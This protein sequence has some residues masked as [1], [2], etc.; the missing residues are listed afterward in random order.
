MTRAHSLRLAVLACLTLVAAALV[1]ALQ[2]ARAAALHEAEADAHTRQLLSLLDANPATDHLH[3]ALAAD[4]VELRFVA[5]A[6]GVY[7]R[8]SVARHVIEIDQQWATADDLTL[9]AVVAHEATHA[10]DAVNG[11]L[12]SGEA[13]A[14]IDS[15]VRA[16]RTA[17]RFWLST[18]GPPGKP[19]A[20][21]EL[22]IQLNSIAAQQ[23]RDPDGL[24]ELIRQTYAQQCTP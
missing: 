23:A 7:A 1:P 11:F 6:P 19:D 15:E 12:A 24:E 17:A 9:A 10:Q 16:F 21:S 3:E 5:L 14:C 22:E 18:F 20:S 4:N 13:S 2:F 8:Y